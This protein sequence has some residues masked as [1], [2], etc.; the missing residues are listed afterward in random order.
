MQLHFRSMNPLFILTFRW[1][2][3]DIK[4]EVDLAKENPYVAIAAKKQRNL[5]KK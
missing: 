1:K 4:M 2:I 5:K 3:L